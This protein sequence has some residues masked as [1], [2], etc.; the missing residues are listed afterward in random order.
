[1]NT[2]REIRRLCEKVTVN[3]TCYEAPVFL[4]NLWLRFFNRNLRLGDHGG[5]RS[6]ISGSNLA[7]AVLRTDILTGQV[8]FGVTYR[9]LHRYTLVYCFVF[10][11]HCL[12]IRVPLR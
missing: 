4:H 5:M 11:L 3:T 9:P 6:I 10:K 8:L 7:D 1:M 2:R 12:A